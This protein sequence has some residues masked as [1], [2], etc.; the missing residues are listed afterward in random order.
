M[1]ITQIHSTITNH[2]AN[3]SNS[4]Y[5]NDVNNAN[6]ENDKHHANHQHNVNVMEIECHLEICRAIRG[7]Q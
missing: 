1:Q 6:S 4:K 3:T 2:E 7:T 5:A